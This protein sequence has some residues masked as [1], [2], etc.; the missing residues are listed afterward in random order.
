MCVLLNGHHVDAYMYM[1]IRTLYMYLLYTQLA[2]M[3]HVLQGHYM[4]MRS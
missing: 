3:M 1:Y 2:V 4:Y